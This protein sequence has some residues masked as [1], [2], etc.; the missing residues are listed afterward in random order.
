MPP[1]E[2]TQEEQQQQ[3]PQD[4]GTPFQPA[5]PAPDPGGGVINDPVEQASSDSVLDDTHPA[6]DTGNQPEEQYDEGV[7]GAAEA[8]EPNAG[9]AVT[10]FNPPAA[11]PG[12]TV[13]PN[14]DPSAESSPPG[15]QDV[16]PG[17]Q[18]PA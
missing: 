16:S 2:P 14:H 5:A 18:P 1:D 11:Q 3:L 7:S 15:G 12:S 10:D 4:N 17:E 8:Q 9:N 13:V 6:T